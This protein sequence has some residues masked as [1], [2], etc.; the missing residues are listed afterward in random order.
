MT[1]QDKVKLVR[2]NIVLG[3]V[4]Y[5]ELVGK[6]YLYVFENGFLEMYFG[7]DNYMHLTGVGSRVNSKQFYELAKEHKLQEKQIFFS[8][9]FPLR[10]AIQKTTCLFDLPNFVKEG[11][12][13]IQ[14][15]ITDTAK[16]PYVIT[17]IDQSI[18]MGLKM[19]DGT[20]DIY[21]PKS[22]RVNGKIFEKAEKDKIFEINYILS[23]TDKE[24][25]YNTILYKDNTKLEELDK[26]ILDKI[27]LSILKE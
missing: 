7:T 14:D 2:D 23:K 21:I 24:R 1:H 8:S 3:A 4:V 17:N 20:D 11:Y 16:Y 10:T 18:L 27:D 13:I 6:Y 9:R 25:K 12:F 22:F 15:L 19:E 5:K 26:I